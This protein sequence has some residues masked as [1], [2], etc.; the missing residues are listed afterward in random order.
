MSKSATPLS[1]HDK[2]IQLDSEVK[3]TK[4]RVSA[5]EKQ[6]VVTQD[7]TVSVNKLAVN[8]DNMCKEQ[9]K[10]G[11]RLDKM[12]RAPLEDAKYYKR[13]IVSCII[14]TVVGAIVGAV[15]CLILK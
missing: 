4:R 10:Q 8:M 14:T 5:L 1:D 13:Q 15:L 7:L 12:E 2:I 9:V 11:E 6:L 3:S